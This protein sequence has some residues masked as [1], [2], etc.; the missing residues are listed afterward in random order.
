MDWKLLVN[1]F[2]PDWQRR[3]LP[4][5]LEAPSTLLQEVLGAR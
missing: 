5:E 3:M 4:P 1:R 2:V